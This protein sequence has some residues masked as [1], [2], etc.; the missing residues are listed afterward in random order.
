MPLWT[1]CLAQ[2]LRRYAFAPVNVVLAS[3]WRQ[4]IWI[5]TNAV[6][7]VVID[8]QMRRYGFPQKRVN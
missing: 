3:T 2:V 8:I 1:M 4:V 7:T 5:T 6:T